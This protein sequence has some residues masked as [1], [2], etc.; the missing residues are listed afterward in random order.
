[1]TI[2]RVTIANI[3]PDELAKLGQDAGLAGTTFPALGFG[4]WGLEPGATAELAGIPRA[5]LEA[6][7]RGILQARSEAAAYLTADGTSPVLLWASGGSEAL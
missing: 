5:E 2:F 3:T 4:S 1:L 7:T 6:W